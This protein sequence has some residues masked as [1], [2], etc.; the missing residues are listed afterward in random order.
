MDFLISEPSSGDESPPI[1][2][3]NI[4]KKRRRAISTTPS[5][6]EAPPVTDN[7][8]D[9]QK[10]DNE[11]KAPPPSKASKRLPTDEERLAAVRHAPSASLAVNIMEVADSIEQMAASNLKGTYVRRLRDDAGKARASATELAKRTT[12]AD[13]QIA[14][15]QE[16]L[17]LRAKLQKANE[18][19]EN[20]KKRHTTER[21]DSAK[22]KQTVEPPVSE[23]EMQEVVYPKPPR[24]TSTGANRGTK[25]RSDQTEEKENNKMMKEIQSLAEQIGALKEIVFKYII[26]GKAV[27]SIET[28][29]QELPDETGKRIK[30]HKE[31]NKIQEKRERPAKKETSRTTGNAEVEITQAPGTKEKANTW[32]RV[33]GRREKEIVRKENK[34]AQ[35]M[36]QAKQR[37]GQFKRKQPPTKGDNRSERRPLKPPRRAAVA[38]TVVPGS[39]KD[40]VD[41]LTTAREK[42]HLPEIG[43]PSAKIR[44]T[45]AGGILVEV[46]GDESADKADK[47]AAK[48]REIFPEDG[49]V[50]ISRPT[51]GSEIRISG[52][53]PTIKAEEIIEAVA[54][55]GRCDKKDVKVGEIKKRSPRGMG[56]AWVQ[57]PIMAAKALAD[58]E[59]ITIGWT[60]ARVEVLK[61]RPMTCYRCM[62]RGHTANNCTSSTDRS[63]RCYNCGE[64]GH[65]AKNCTASPRCPVCSDEGRPANHRF[66]GKRATHQ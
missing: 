2:R 53:D 21:N 8:N 50:K 66:G 32:A 14:L 15:E 11:L 36:Q 29:P 13:A 17:Q 40:Y 49:E 12:V 59:R 42:I 23:S 18:E 7:E 58:K 46:P 60:A 34:V 28:A 39:D 62:E 44:Y 5:G 25:Q 24:Q 33:V 57:C 35:K 20:L 27:K 54:T 61:A 43:I 4:K 26:D 56:A 47:L 6:S 41:V 48:L 16:N 38:L 45:V 63:K 19:I 10:K 30:N 22:G 3:Q 52:L 1:R 9:D 55:I 65:W 51:K 64:E 31:E 37:Q